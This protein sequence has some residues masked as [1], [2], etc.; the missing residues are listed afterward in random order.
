[1][2]EQTEEQTAPDVR[3]LPWR[4]VLVLGVLLPLA[5]ASLLV[6]SATD[7][8]SNIDL[9][10]VAIVNNDTI[11]TD[12]Q[13]MAAGRSLTAALTHPS[14]PSNNLLWVLTDSDDA[15]AGLANG[16]YYAVLTIPSDFSEAV[17]STGTDTP[18]QGQL[19]LVSNAAASTTM[20]YI[21]QQVATA[22]AD[23]LGQQVTQ[24]Y[25]GQVYDGFNSLADGNQKAATSAAQLAEGTQQLSA[26]ATQLDQG[27]ESLS[28]GL[29]E[30]ATG[31]EELAD[32]ASTV[33]SGAV[34]VASGTAQLAQGV[35]KL[36]NGQASLAAGARTLSGDAG[37]LAARSRELARGA[38]VAELGT[39]AVSGGARLLAKEMARL[40]QDCHAAL[41]SP[42]FCNRLARAVQHS[43]RLADGARRV[44][45]GAAA[46]VASGA[47]QLAD[48]AGGLARG[49][50]RLSASA[51]ALSDAGA[52]LSGSTKSLV[53]GT[54]SLAQGTAGLDSAAG[55]LASG[56]RSTA[57]AGSS[58]ASGSSTLASSAN[59]ADDGAQQLSSGLASGAAQS[60]TYSDEQQQALAPV[61]SKPILLTSTVEHGEHGNGWL[62]A[63]IVG[64]V[65]WLAGLVAALSLDQS[66]I[67]RNSMAPV[68][69][70]GAAF[71]QALPLLGLAALSAASVV[72]AV[73]V[74]HASTAAIIPLALLTLLASVIFALLAL[75]MRLRWGRVGITLFVLFLLVQIAASSNVIPLETA[76]STL[77][78]LNGVMPLT[79]YVNGASQLVSG[80]QVGSLVAVVVVLL[81]WGLV[82]YAL[83]V[84]AVKK[85]RMLDPVEPG[86]AA[87]SP[88]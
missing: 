7:R 80:G 13:P 28:Q 10:P 17:L 44:N 69:S 51:H 78:R 25:L 79:A 82:A 6:W 26:G 37:R 50:A 48:G 8:Q 60:P 88:V 9:V 56:T 57:Q 45:T 86:R 70:R 73:V 21:S 40:G 49:S 66:A 16:G 39:R 55:Q 42:A 74:F 46:K 5:A 65:L 59:Q 31:S 72:A 43:A 27:A 87:L 34:Q 11:I 3:R 62:I 54:A 58:L 75:A 68:A 36:T 38:R 24:G 23:A 29:G 12:P 22:A 15:H 76:P 85:K 52:R 19:R 20:P 41:G 67:T 53:Q 84:S 2:S 1:M 64:L 47:S 30:V 18:V 77:Q 35:T 63:V 71:V 32:G 61:V 33:H 81:V 14:D 83:L 4:R